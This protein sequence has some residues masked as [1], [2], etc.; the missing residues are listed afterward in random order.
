MLQ[1]AF[2]IML[3]TP[4]NAEPIIVLRHA[5]KSF[6]DQLVVDDLN[7]TVANGEVVALLGQTGVGKTTILNLILGQIK[8]SSGTVVVDGCDPVKDYRAL[9]GKVAVSFQS[10]R[11]LPWRTARGNVELG[12]EIIRCP[13]AE[14]SGRA[15]EWLNRVKLR[16]QHHDKYPHQLSGG[17]RQRVSLARA[18]VIDPDLVLLD[19]SFSQLDQVTSRA[20]RFDFLSLVKQLNKTCVLVTHRIEDAVE[21]ADRVI[22]L[23]GQAAIKLDFA[24]SSAQRND[25]SALAAASRLIAAEMESSQRAA[26]ENLSCGL[27]DVTR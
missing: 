20:L 7:L 2:P 24:L 21:M 10:D 4:A 23:A 14:R 6:D 19:E 5:S 9:R 25:P 18:L 26:D 27:N 16:T 15:T 17:M 11:L 12:L 3:T 8:P 22:V 13:K 1:P